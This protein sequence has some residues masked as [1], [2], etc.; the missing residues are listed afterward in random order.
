[1]RQSECF[2]TGEETAV[3]GVNN[4]L[5]TD[6]P[7]TKEPS[8]ETLECVLSALNL[9]EFDVDIAFGIRIERDMDDMTVFVLAL[10]ANVIFELLYPAVTLFSADLVSLVPLWIKN[11]LTHRVQM[12]SE[13]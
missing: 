3:D 10:G 6:L 8:I 7:T 1:M 11:K 5:S 9:L 2:G 13:V 12:R 4:W